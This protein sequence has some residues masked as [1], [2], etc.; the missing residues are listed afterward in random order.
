MAQAAAITLNDGQATPVA[1]TFNPESVTPAL[2]SFADRSSG[3][4]IGF[5]KVKVSNTF[6]SGKSTVNRAKMTVEVPVLQTVDGVQVVAYTMRA[7]LEFLLPDGST[8]ANRKDV[9]AFVLN[10]LSNSLVRGAL[11]DLDP[12]Y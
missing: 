9:Y 2:S 12:L 7:N 6:A 11:R 5:R 1:V 4:A 10:A 3:I 8:D